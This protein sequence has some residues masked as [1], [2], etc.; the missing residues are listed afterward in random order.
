M[1]FSVVSGDVGDWHSDRSFKHDGDDHNNVEESVGACLTADG[2]SV[3]AVLGPHRP[4][5][6]SSRRSSPTRRPRAPEPTNSVRRQRWRRLTSS[7]PP[8]MSRCSAGITSSLTFS[9]RVSE[10]TCAK[11]DAALRLGYS[12]LTAG[13]VETC[14]GRSLG[15]SSKQWVAMTSSSSSS[16]SLNSWSNRGSSSSVTQCQPSLLWSQCRLS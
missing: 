14:F 10:L 15:F 3:A 12:S 7:W 4:P 1:L 8:V 6:A 11:D 2:R 16:S 13:R 5:V 9:S